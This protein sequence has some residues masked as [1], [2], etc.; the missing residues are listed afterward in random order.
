MFEE[1]KIGFDKETMRFLRRQ[2]TS[3]RHRAAQDYIRSLVKR[4]FEAERNQNSLWL[5][6]QLRPGLLAA[7]DDFLSLDAP[8]LIAEARRRAQTHAG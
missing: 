2:K 3:G 1:L 6:N 5:R 7:E 4:E 8:S